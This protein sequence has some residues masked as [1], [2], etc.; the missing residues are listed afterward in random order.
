[1][2]NL[3]KPLTIM[4]ALT[5]CQVQ[6]LQS[7]EESATESSN[8]LTAS[9]AWI[10]IPPPGMHMLAAYGEFNNNSEQAIEIS[11]ATSDSFKS[12]GMHETVITDGISRMVAQESVVIEA[13]ETVTFEPGGL[14]FMLMSPT[15][16]ELPET[17]D[18]ELTTADGETYTIEFSFRS[19]K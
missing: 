15:Y 9:D 7:K 14:H 18:I 8:N 13:G 11:S 2:K 19:S 17:A 12:V 3:V 4:L 10:R 1:M 5:A 6:Q 16:K